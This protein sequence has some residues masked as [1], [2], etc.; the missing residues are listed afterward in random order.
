MNVSVSS[1]EKY[2]ALGLKQCKQ[3]LFVQ[4]YGVNE[5]KLSSHQDQ[6]KD[7]GK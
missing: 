2:I 5:N 1:V 4:G 7:G 6:P 3:S